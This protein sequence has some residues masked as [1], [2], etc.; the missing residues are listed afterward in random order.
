MKLDRETTKEMRE[1]ELVRDLLKSEGW[2]VVKEMLNERIMVLDSI[3]T[4]PP[5]MPVEEIG[6]Q[7]MYRAYAI[8]LINDW[9]RSIEARAEQFEQQAQMLAE[10][11]AEEVVRTYSSS[12]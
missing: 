4:I 1:G 3:S 6:R 2:G 8:S 7:A 12:A 5:D 11:H 9:L 10:V